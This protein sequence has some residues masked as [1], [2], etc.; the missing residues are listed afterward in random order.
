MARA[1]DACRATRPDFFAWQASGAVFDIV[2]L[3]VMAG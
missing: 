3:D 2:A 1:I